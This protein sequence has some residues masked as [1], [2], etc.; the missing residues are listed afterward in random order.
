MT[1][2][3]LPL[4]ASSTLLRFFST[5]LHFPQPPVPL[6]PC[7]AI[8]EINSLGGL[9]K[10][11][12]PSS[13][14]KPQSLARMHLDPALEKQLSA[15][16]RSAKAKL[17]TAHEQGLFKR[18]GDS[19]CARPRSNGRAQNA[20]ML[21]SGQASA[22]SSASPAHVAAHG[23]KRTKVFIGSLSSLLVHLTL[24]HRLA[25]RLY[26]KPTSVL[27]ALSSKMLSRCSLRFS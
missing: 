15:A 1:P 18:L 21:I 13:G 7:Q 16:V 22:Y 17:G 25:R 20:N 24:R 27:G 10:L 5:L 4:S 19:F 26:T 8:L 2:V 3:S 11:A 12:G 9:D 6:R 23:A 14:S